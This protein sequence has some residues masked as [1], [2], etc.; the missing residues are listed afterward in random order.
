MTLPLKFQRQDGHTEGEERSQCHSATA[1][2]LLKLFWIL[3]SDVTPWTWTLRPKYKSVCPFLCLTNAF[4][5]CDNTEE[6]A[7]QIFV[8]HEGSFSLV[9]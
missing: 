7:V 1:N 4:V 2:Y 5:Y 9:F 8:P 6:K 3:G